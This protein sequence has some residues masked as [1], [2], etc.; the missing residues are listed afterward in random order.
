MGN[1]RRDNQKLGR[2]FNSRDNDRPAMHKA[3]CSECSVIC[4]VP[5]RPT[6]ERPVF[7]SNCFKK[8]S[9]GGDRSSKFGDKRRERSDY[10]DRQ[11]YNV[12]CDK[13]GKNCQV[14]FKPTA[15]KPIFCDSCFKQDG[16]GSGSGGGSR[17]SEKIMDQINLLNVKMDKL[18]GILTPKSS[19]EK[20]EKPKIKKVK[21]EIIIKKTTKKKK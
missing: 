6:G 18:I 1:F 20:T 7:C 21:K 15:G 11:M 19:I 5:F 12:V 9:G 4:E 16:S 14:P 13:C 8:Q 2:S 3:T 10:G 17:D